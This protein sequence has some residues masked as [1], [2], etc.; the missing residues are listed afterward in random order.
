MKRPVTI[1]DILNSVDFELLQSVLPQDE[2]G[3][4]I[5]RLRSYQSAQRSELFGGGATPPALDDIADLQL[6]LN[7]AMLTLIQTLGARFDGLA[8]QVRRAEY[9]QLRLDESAP[10][11]LPT[12]D[13]AGNPPTSLTPLAANLL[14]RASVAAN[15]PTGIESQERAIRECMRAGRLD[16]WIDARPVQIPLI[17]GLLTRLRRSLHELVIFYVKRLAVEQTAINQTYG[18]ALL[19]LE[20][21]VR[22]QESLLRQAAESAPE[23]A[24]RA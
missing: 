16:P 18:S 19:A 1:D 23:T 4:G 21:A 2:L 8:E 11:P 13:Y 3:E 12:P 24:H 7:E 22:V 17:G 10:L 5:A 14:D 6:R 15:A 20:Q 9:L